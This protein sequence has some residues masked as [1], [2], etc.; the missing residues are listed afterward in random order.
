MASLRRRRLRVA[1]PSRSKVF[2]RV[3]TDVPAPKHG[4]RPRGA[5]GAAPSNEPDAS[6][7]GTGEIN[8]LMRNEFRWRA[9]LRRRR[10]RGAIA[11]GA[12][13]FLRNE[14]WRTGGGRSAKLRAKV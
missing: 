12:K 14:D 9:S 8:L 6:E 4:A 1:I 7:L 5:D 3:K 11:A 13:V 10:L 2:F